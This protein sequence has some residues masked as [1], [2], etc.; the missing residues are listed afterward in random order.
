M[1]KRE[2]RESD[3]KIRL[4][5]RQSDG[6]KVLLALLLFIVV[7]CIVYAVI[8]TGIKSKKQVITEQ[9]TNN[10]QQ[11]NNY[12]SNERTFDN[13]DETSTT[14]LGNFNTSTYLLK[15]D[16]LFGLSQQ[17]LKLMRNEIFA[18]HGYIFNSKDLQDYFSKQSWYYPQYTDVSDKLNSIERQNIA[19][20]KKYEEAKGFY[21]EN[22]EKTYSERL[23][24]AKAFWSTLPWEDKSN[25]LNA[26]RYRDIIAERYHIWFD[27]GDTDSDAFY[28]TN[29]KDI[30]GKYYLAGRTM[31]NF[32][33]LRKSDLDKWANSNGVPITAL[34]PRTTISPQWYKRHSYEECIEILK[35]G[36]ESEDA[37]EIGQIL[38]RRIEDNVYYQEEIREAVERFQNLGYLSKVTNSEIEEFF[39]KELRK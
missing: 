21:D 15:E 9:Q 29:A 4:S 27:L 31:D 18:R 11:A 17:E 32:R 35:Y 10:G 33:I 37:D 1:R 39:K 23:K 30:I 12:S 38:K 20:I 36:V 14:N 28:L 6:T 13:D 8:Y 22:T 26:Y 19:F 2:I 5:K 16:D 24:D 25:P 34:D 7:G 3:N